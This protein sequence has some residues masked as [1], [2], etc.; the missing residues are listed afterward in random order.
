MRAAK[1]RFHVMVIPSHRFG[2]HLEP[3]YD[4]AL[5]VALPSPYP[6]PQTSSSSCTALFGPSVVL[7][8]CSTVRDRLNSGRNGQVIPFLLWDRSVRYQFAV[9][10][11]TGTKQPI[12]RMCIRTEGE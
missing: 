4:T 6:H 7:A 11:D 3:T 9:L 1:R 8:A 5:P 10:A 2:W 12:A